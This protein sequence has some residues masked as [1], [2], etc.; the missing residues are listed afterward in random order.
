M[1]L[2]KSKSKPAFEHNLKA[3]LSAGKPKPQALAI[4]YSVKRKA[5][6]MAEGGMA[7]AKT[8]SRP[9]PEKRYNDSRDLMSADHK[10]AI[11]DS[12]WTSR[13]PEKA[14]TAEPKPK[15]EAILPKIASSGVF[16]TRRLDALGNPLDKD[17]L[18]LEQR[19]APASDKM[20]PP[21]HMDEDRPDR[22]GPPV[23]KM[24]MMADG[25]M[26]PHDKHLE[27]YGAEAEEDE[28]EHPAGL[29]SDND[30]MALPESEFMAKHFE[31]GGEAEPSPTP[32]STPTDIH[33]P[34]T[35]KKM[36]GLTNGFEHDPRSFG[37]I[38]QHAKE[39]F[40][41][42]AFGGE[43]GDE[44]DDE[45]HSSIAAAIMAKM[46]K[47]HKMAEGGQV[48]LDENAEE[49]PNAYYHEDD[50]ALKENYDEGMHSAIDPMDSD[51]HGHSL[52]DEDEHENSMIA[53][54]RRKM[55]KRSPITR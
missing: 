34:D 45:H 40:F 10:A 1:P 32:D 26:M 54:I 51:E 5:K 3:E 48:D 7:T 33:D 50:A 38:I 55:M 36:R 24:K 47:L 17:E 27:E 35:R 28:V 11:R 53:A 29:E 16:K 19:D 2:F 15:L 52:P 39:E 6:K 22:Q 13:T 20:L 43:V 21:K 25:G 44:E 42:K 37:D 31:N 46:H 9:M 49:E 14:A 18:H 41:G 30:E 4:A 12:T 8:E 23:H